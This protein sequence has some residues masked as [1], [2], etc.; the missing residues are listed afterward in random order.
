MNLLMNGDK[1]G[2]SKVKEMYAEGFEYKV[3]RIKDGK[4]VD[5][6]FIYSS[7]NNKKWMSKEELRS[8]IDTKKDSIGVI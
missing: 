5:S 8:W 4:K 1:N 3:N 2:M 7:D 6:N